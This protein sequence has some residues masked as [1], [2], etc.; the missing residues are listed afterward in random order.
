[1][2]TWTDS[3]PLATMTIVAVAAALLTSAMLWS[4]ALSAD[5]PVAPRFAVSV[6]SLA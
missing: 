4:L 2:H 6:F 5:L 3:K 1:M